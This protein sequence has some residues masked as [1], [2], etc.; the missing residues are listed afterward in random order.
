MSLLGRYSVNIRYSGYLV[1]DIRSNLFGWTECSNNWWTEYRLPNPKNHTFDFSTPSHDTSSLL[2]MI[3]TLYIDTYANICREQFP[4][5]TENLDIKTLRGLFIALW[6]V[7]LNQDGADF[8]S[9]TIHKPFK[10]GQLFFK[11]QIYRGPIFHFDRV[12]K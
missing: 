9:N 6:Q 10:C 3:H 4:R 7:L 11:C 1:F 8:L 5:N 12:W 2:Y